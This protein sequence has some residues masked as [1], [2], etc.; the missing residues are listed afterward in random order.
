MTG[1]EPAIQCLEGASAKTNLAYTGKNLVHVG[2]FEPPEPRLVTVLLAA[3]ANRICLTC[4]NWRK[5]SESN[6]HIPK[7]GPLRTGWARQMPSASQNNLA[8]SNSAAESCPPN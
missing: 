7:D 2:G 1:I 5:R 8:E 6:A 4:T 3:A